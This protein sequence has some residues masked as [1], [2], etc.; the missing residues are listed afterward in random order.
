ME[1]KIVSFYELKKKYGRPVVLTDE[2]L[3]ALGEEYQQAE[4]N[5]SFYQWVEL[6]LINVM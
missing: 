4:T 5:L 6:Q 1:E 2:L 3:D